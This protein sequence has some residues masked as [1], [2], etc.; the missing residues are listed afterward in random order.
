MFQDELE[1]RIWPRNDSISRQGG[2]PRVTFLTDPKARSIMD[3]KTK[4]NPVELVI[5]KFMDLL[6]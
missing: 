4:I 6:R 5:D 2:R 3:K 1:D